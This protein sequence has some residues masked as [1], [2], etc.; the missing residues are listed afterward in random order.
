VAVAEIEAAQDRTAGKAQHLIQG[1]PTRTKKPAALS[2]LLYFLD[3]WELFF[4][5]EFARKFFLTALKIFIVDKA[6][7]YRPRYASV[8]PQLFLARR[9]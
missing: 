9:V 2:G 4:T 1:S 8:M 5:R 6:W 7:Q 3:L